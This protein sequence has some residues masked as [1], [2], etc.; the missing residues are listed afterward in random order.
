MLDTLARHLDLASIS[1]C[2]F[3]LVYYKE[4]KLRLLDYT[5]GM[6]ERFIR[7]IVSL[8]GSTTNWEITSRSRGSGVNIKYRLINFIH[9]KLNC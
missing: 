2:R 7:I 8:V 4:I 3:H 5:T 1:F 9:V 6:A